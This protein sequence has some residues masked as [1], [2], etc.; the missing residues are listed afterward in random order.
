M[1]QN[2]VTGIAAFKTFEAVFRA[3]AVARQ[4]HCWSNFWQVT[5]SGSPLQS[6]HLTIDSLFIGK[7]KNPVVW[8]DNLF[9]SR[10][11]LNVLS[12]N[13][14]KWNTKQSMWRDSVLMQH[15]FYSSVL[16]G[17][18]SLTE[19][20]IASLIHSHTFSIPFLIRHFPFL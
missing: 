19:R 8:N 10:Y 7:Y 16:C 18:L 4:N 9:T 11:C 13:F 2:Y 14:C 17:F 15:G 6:S 20:L 3:D 12:Q 1:T 5:F